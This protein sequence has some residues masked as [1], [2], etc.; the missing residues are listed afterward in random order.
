[1]KKVRYVAALAGFA[2]AAAA[3]MTGTAAHAAAAAG[4]P[5]QHVPARAKSAKSVSLRHLSAR[6]LAPDLVYSCFGSHSGFFDHCNA[7]II[8]NTWLFSPNGNMLQ[9]LHPGNR[10]EVTC[11]YRSASHGRI[12]DHV[13]REHVNSI[14]IHSVGHVSDRFVSFSNTNPSGAGLAHC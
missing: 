3:A 1:M 2:P 7:P 9:P 4:S 12:Q 13:V 6:T 8:G 14:F 10:V 11:W 5:G